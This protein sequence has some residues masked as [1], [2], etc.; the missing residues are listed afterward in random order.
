MIP[1][2]SVKSNVGQL[3]R[4]I[5]VERQDIPKRT[6]TALTRTASEVRKG[7]QDEMR[8]VF[9]RPTRFTL[10]SL[11]LKG[12]RAN[13]LTAVVWLKQR[14]SLGGPHYL[15]PQ[16][17]GGKRPLKPFE[18]RLRAIVVLLPG[19]YVVPGERA[20]LDSS[21][22]MSRGQLVQILSQLR[23][24]GLAG[25]GSD[26]QP[27]G[28]KRSRRN[29]KRAGVFFAGRPNKAS[30]LGVWQRVG[31]GARPVLIFVRGVRYQ[32]RFKFYEVS[33]R[34]SRRQFPL[35]FERAARESAARKSLIR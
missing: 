31:N 5:G 17:F 33:E 32:S 12:A 29:V 20:K 3:A 11:F 24:I 25:Q 28:S 1:T 34:I 7:L 2:L 26:A 9:D 23:A 35:Q 30:P 27:T 8:R 16:I 6:A 13:D 15:E 21:G 14:N 18:R 22:N 19:W 4:R 10:N